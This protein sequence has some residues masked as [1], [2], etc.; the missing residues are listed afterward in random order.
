MNHQLKF[1]MKA[2]FVGSV[3]I[4]VAACASTGV[5]SVGDN[6]YMI[7]KKDGSPGLGVSL[8]TKAAV[9]AEAAAFCSEQ[10]GYINPSKTLV[11][12]TVK[13]DTIPAKL[14]QLG[15]TELIFRC[16]PSVQR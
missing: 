15:S 16:V 12:E 8:S 14:A 7:G 10:M 6:A 2:S 11:V 1:L 3:L 13:I 9:Y 5:I 4:I